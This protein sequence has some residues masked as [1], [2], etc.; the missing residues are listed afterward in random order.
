MHKFTPAAAACVCVLCYHVL[1]VLQ[2]RLMVESRRDFLCY[3]CCQCDH[4]PV[5]DKVRL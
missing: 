4:L 5:N 2:S 3:A 1:L